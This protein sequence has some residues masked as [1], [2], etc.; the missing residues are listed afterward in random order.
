MYFLKVIF[1]FLLLQINAS[2]S[3]FAQKNQSIL[4]KKYAPKLL[5]EDS[6]VLKEVML[7]MH[8]AIGLYYPRTFY[9][10][11]F[12][13][14]INQLKDS[15]TEKQYRISLKTLLDVL[16]CGHTEVGLS[17]NSFKAI[18]KLKLN[19]SPLVF[20]PL[21][22]KVYFIASTEKKWDTLI[23][24]VS[25]IIAIN[26]V[27]TDSMQSQI[28]RLIS[29]DGYNTSGKQH[30]LSLAFNS[31]FPAIYSR[32]DTF[33]VEYKSGK[34]IKKIKYPA[35]KTQSFPPIPLGGRDTLFRTYRKAG[36][37]TK[38]LD[39]GNTTL[40]LKIEKFSHLKYSKA[41]RKIFR[42]AKYRQVQN[43]IIDL[44]NNGGGSLANSYKLL[45]YLLDTSLTQTLKTG[46]SNYPYRKYTSGNFWFKITKLGFKLVGKKL[47]VSDTDNY[48]YTIRPHQKY[49]Y[50]KKII[51]LING[52]SFSASCLVSAYLKY[53]NRAIFIGEETGG[54]LEGCNAGVTPY[55]T[56]PNTKV[57]I[58]VPAFRIIHDVSPAITGRGIMPDYKIEYTIKDIFAKRDLELMKAM[59][60]LGL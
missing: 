49:H 9:Q 39:Q 44:R 57:K 31:Y 15:L 53:K 40:L 19:Y 38:F 54:A 55:Y 11:Y 5:K 52:G 58:R 4:T 27:L 32:P 6:K 28:P 35:F 13:N 10:S 47:V 20:L 24:K 3:L 50:H 16:H 18:K 59:E 26:G 43:L 7:A 14:Y 51:V 34:E 1:L 22:G 37:K 29:G 23:K 25:Q 2:T 17:N 12:D 46:I 8:P 33:E 56:L 60:L 30:Y 36:I 42:E 41:Y 21:N 45:A 48:V